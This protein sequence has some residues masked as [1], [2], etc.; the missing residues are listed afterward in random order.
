MIYKEGKVK[1]DRTDNRAHLYH[2]VF[3]ELDY[4]NSGS[5][6]EDEV[7]KINDR[8]RRCLQK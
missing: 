1:L 2:P 6:V 3:H 7:A 4:K 5:T 8:N